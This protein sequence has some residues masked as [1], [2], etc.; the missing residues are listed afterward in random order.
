MNGIHVGDW[1]LSIT[2][3]LLGAILICLIAKK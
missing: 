1:Y 3:I 2:N